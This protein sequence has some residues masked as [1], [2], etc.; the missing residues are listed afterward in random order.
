MCI[1]IDIPFPHLIYF[2][3]EKERENIITSH[4]QQQMNIE[5][6]TL[7]VEAGGC[8]GPFLGAGSAAAK[9]GNTPDVSAY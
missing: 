6:L 8:Q 1:G 7:Y 9:P 3:T 4:D 2:Y 5:T